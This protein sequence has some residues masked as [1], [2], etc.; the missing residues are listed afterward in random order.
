SG[1]FYLLTLD[2]KR[3]TFTLHKRHSGRDVKHA[4]KDD[5]VPLVYVKTVEF[6]DDFLKR[7]EAA[8]KA[9]AAKAPVA[10]PLE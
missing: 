4:K 2:G 7:I 8:K 6:T 1:I 5:L 9:E 10:K 3:T